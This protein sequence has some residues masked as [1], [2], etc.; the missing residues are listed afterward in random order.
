[1]IKTPS[2]FIKTSWEN[3]PFRFAYQ[4]RWSSAFLHRVVKNL[5]CEG[6]REVYS[7]EKYKVYILSEYIW[8]IT[9][10]LGQVLNSKHSQICANK[11]DYVGQFI[12]N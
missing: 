1:M 11:M 10:I 7:R 3:F 4:P 9:Q 6:Q 2:L 12:W 8:L 5:A